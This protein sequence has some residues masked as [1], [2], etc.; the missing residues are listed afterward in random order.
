M[1]AF[2]RIELGEREWTDV[3]LIYEIQLL[4]SGEP[5]VRIAWITGSSNAD[6]PVD[7]TDG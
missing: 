4:S 7:M 3:I 2:E 1:V 5:D 6:G